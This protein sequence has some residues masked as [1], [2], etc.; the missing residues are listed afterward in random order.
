[1][2]SDIM[3]PGGVSGL[4]LARE[5]RRR[6]PNMPVVLTTG[7]VESVSEMKDGEF[8]LLLKPFSLEALADALGVNSTQ[9]VR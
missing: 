5:I 2:L 1:V 6:Y 4:H 3:M 9:D 7:Y 8:A